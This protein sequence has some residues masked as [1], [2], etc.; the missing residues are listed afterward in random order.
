MEGAVVLLSLLAVLL[1]FSYRAGKN[2]EITEGQED[3]I[4]AIHKASGAKRNLTDESRR[5]LWNKY[6]KR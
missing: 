1:F 3:Y 4:D 2:K 5:V 6:L